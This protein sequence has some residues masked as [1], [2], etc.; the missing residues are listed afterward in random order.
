[1][2]QVPAKNSSYLLIGSGRLA[3]HLIHYFGLV[4][5]PLNLWNRRD[6]SAAELT[7]LVGQSDKILLAIADQAIEKFV[8][9]HDFSGKS[10]IHFSGALTVPRTTSAH[11]L[12]TFSERFYDLDFYQKIPFI[13]EQDGPDFPQIFPELPNPSFRIA[14]EKKAFYHSLCVMAGNFTG[15]LWKKLFQEFEGELAIPKE[16]ALP[17]LQAVMQ[18]LMQ[19]PQQALTGPLVRKDWATVDKNLHA[20]QTDSF[21][22]V[23]L[24]FL[25]SFDA[26][27]YKGL[28]L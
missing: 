20:L 15:L 11:P 6:H 18:N 12:M 8:A 1:M 4:K 2:R 28:N 19:N 22:P 24:G 5:I 17:Y 25:K 9:E 26:E 23:Y 13:L 3:K 21:L 14:A 16:A 27:K 7:Q 10:I